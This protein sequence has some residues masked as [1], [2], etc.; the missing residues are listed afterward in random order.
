MGRRLC[1]V[2]G[3]RYIVGA[4]ISLVNYFQFSIVEAQAVNRYVVLDG[5]NLVKE[6]TI[7]QLKDHLEAMKLEETAIAAQFKDYVRVGGTQCR[8]Q[9]DKDLLAL[10]KQQIRSWYEQTADHGK[11]HTVVVPYQEQGEWWVVELNGKTLN[12]WIDDKGVV[13]N[14]VTVPGSE[15]RGRPSAGWSLFRKAIIAEGCKTVLRDLD[16]FRRLSDYD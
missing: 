1:F 5:K 8:R 4:L 2:K 12:L 10:R 13:T 3:N 15:N 7:Y 14:K 11:C 16:E 9:S 6:G